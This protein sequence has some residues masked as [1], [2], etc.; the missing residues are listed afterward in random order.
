[1]NYIK[2]NRNE[3]SGESLDYSLKMKVTSYNAKV[4]KPAKQLH[5]KSH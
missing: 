5:Q 3:L 4:E 1:M 2:A